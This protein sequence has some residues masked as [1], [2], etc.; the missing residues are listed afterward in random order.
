MDQALLNLVLALATNEIAHNL[1]EATNVRNKVK[2]LH[3]YINK[4]PVD[5]I[6]LNIDTRQKAYGISVIMFVIFVG[7]LYGIFSMLNLAGNDALW[8]VVVAL[9]IAYFVSAV[10]LDKYHVEI[11][12]VTRPFMKKK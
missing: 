4:K 5:K 8:V 1:A 2:R 11:E 9:V 3:A 7:I 10:M 12:H 6:P